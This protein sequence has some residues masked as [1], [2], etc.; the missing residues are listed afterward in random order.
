[1]VYRLSL[2]PTEAQSSFLNSRK[3]RLVGTLEWRHRLALLLI[4]GLVLDGSVAQVNLAVGLLLP[5][6]GVLHPVDIVT[7]GVVLTGVSTTG[8]LTVGSGSSGLGTG[9]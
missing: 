1:M 2:G 4:K 9:D 8:L 3:I 6:E 5:G 7:L